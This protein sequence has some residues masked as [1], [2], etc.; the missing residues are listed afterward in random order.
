MLNTIW[1]VEEHS[2]DLVEYS[3]TASVTPRQPRTRRSQQFVCSLNPQGLR[4]AQ[5]WL[6]DYRAFWTG[7]FDRLDEHLKRNPHPPKEK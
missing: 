3:E 6:D 4:S 1:H 7:A 2:W 5:E